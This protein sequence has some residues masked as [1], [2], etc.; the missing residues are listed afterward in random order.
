MGRATFVS[1]SIN[2]VVTPQPVSFTSKYLEMSAFN[3]SIEGRNGLRREP[4][5][6][7]D[8]LSMPLEHFYI[9]EHYQDTLD[10]LLIPS[11]A[12][13]DRIEKLAYDITQDYN[14][15][16]IHLICV[17]KG[18]NGE[19]YSAVCLW[20]TLVLTYRRCHVLWRAVQCHE[21][22]PQL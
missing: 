2:V 4:Y 7:A 21:E 10:G 9:P 16:T 3:S 13:S 5:Y 17:L 18:L 19:I 14:G 11:G 20:I 6:V 22:V 1:A 15:V 8:K 12:I